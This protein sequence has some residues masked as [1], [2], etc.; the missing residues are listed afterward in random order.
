[1]ASQVMGGTRATHVFSMLVLISFFVI[2]AQ[3]AIEEYAPMKILMD[4]WDIRPPGWVGSDPC[5]GGWEDMALTGQ[6]PSDIELLSELE[7]L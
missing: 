7:I 4:E 6:L 1:M 2:A 5:V 3:G